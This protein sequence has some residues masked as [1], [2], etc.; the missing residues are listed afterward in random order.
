M[1]INY[2]FNIDAWSPKFPLQ[3]KH[4]HYDAE[5]ITS[6]SDLCINEQLRVA[7]RDQ[8]DWGRALPIDVFVM[9]EGEPPD[10]HVTK[11]GGLPYRPRE[12]PWPAGPYGFNAVFLG[13]FCFSDSEDIVGKLPGDVLLIFGILPETGYKYCEDVRFEWYPLGLHDL[14][15]AAQVPP[16]PWSFQPCYGYRFRTTAFP[17]APQKHHPDEYPVVNGC[18]VQ[19]PYLLPRYQATQIGRAPYFIQDSAREMF[20]RPL[21]ALNSSQ[22]AVDVAYPF[23]NRSEPIP[24]LEFPTDEW[25]MFG[26]TGC[27]Y[28]SFDDDGQL[29]FCEDSY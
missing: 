28:V 29:H 22:P 27:L 10:R 7:V 11:I 13:Q 2:D 23:I 18:A 4:G 1:G 15:R 20:G 17:D 6:P 3:S 14:V 25:L 9:A 16:Q 12:I 26:D 5:I 24:L 21:C 8:Y 19:S